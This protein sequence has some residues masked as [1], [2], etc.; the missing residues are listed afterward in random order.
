MNQRRIPEETL[1]AYVD[2][3]LDG[4]ARAEVEAA[5][6]DDPSLARE[7]E[8]QRALRQR[9]SAAY[10][11]VLDEPIPPRLLAAA[12]MK[13][14]P[15][16]VVDL[17]AVRAERATPQPAPRS[18][19]AGWGWAQWGGMAACLAIGLFVGRA[20]LGPSADI[21]LHD[22]KLVAQGGLDRMLTQAAAADSDATAPNR[23][24]LTFV[25]KGGDYCR[26][27]SWGAG[28]ANSAGLACRAG[29]GW[30]LRTL[31]RNTTGGEPGGPMRMA[32]SGLP[33]PVLRAVEAEIAGS[34]LD[35]QAERA[36]L[37]AGWRKR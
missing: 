11:P 34:P 17:S 8:R 37:Q 31:A 13:P 15:G 25:S 32:G 7:V 9:L 1:L 5:L 24:G 36:A 3:E 19:R 35:A 28:A 6:H 12:Q 33:E 16:R 27:F 2:G 29:S 21:A 26:T 18:A 14:A 30:E 20:L 10:D 23:V 22:G 4:S